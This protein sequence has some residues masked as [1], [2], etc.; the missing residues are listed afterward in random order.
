M[1]CYFLPSWGYKYINCEV[2]KLPQRL[3]LSYTLVTTCLL[4]SP[5]RGGR[6]F[7]MVGHCLLSILIT[8]MV[9]STLEAQGPSSP[10]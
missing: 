9:D 2:H 4:S 10:V 8:L 1:F 7:R 3:T 5:L 6:L